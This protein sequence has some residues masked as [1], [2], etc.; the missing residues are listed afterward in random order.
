MGQRLSDSEETDNIRHLSD[1]R[2]Y[3]RNSSKYPKENFWNDHV[4]MPVEV[5]YEW[6][7]GQ[8]E[9]RFRSE[10][11]AFIGAGPEDGTIDIDDTKKVK[12][13][14]FHLRFSPS[15]QRYFYND[16]DKTLIISDSS[17]K[18]GGRYR[19]IIRPTIDEP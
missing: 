17:P 18:M 16:T 10:F 15:F 6:G 8:S 9:I 13:E 11:R 19:L 14:D 2:A 5:I 7:N 4:H 1:F 3:W 12:I